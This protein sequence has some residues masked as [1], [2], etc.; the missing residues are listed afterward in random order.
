MYSSASAVG[1]HCH[2]L[3]GSK[4]GWDQ[5]T[6]PTLTQVNSFLDDGN[7]IINSILSSKGY[8][9][10]VASGTDLYGWLGRLESLWGAA[11][12]EFHRTTNSL[13]PGERTRGQVFYEYFWEEFDKLCNMDLTI[14]GGTRLS[15]GRMFAGGITIA[16]KQAVEQNSNLITPR[17]F[18]G[19]ARS[20]DAVYPRPITAS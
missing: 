13:A 19:V 16:D 20:Q 9:T 11:Q 18:K 14:A 4:R 3:L 10:P 7:S 8:A 17:F 5:A 12:A 2:N 1:Q 6:C 15:A